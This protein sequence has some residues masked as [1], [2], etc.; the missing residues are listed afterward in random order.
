MVVEA[1]PRSAAEIFGE[2]LALA[3]KYA[4]LLA[5]NSDTLGLL[6]PRELEKLW[7]RHILNSAAV[8]ELISPGSSVADIGSGAGLPGIPLAIALPASEITLIEPMERRA[9]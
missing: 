7:T 8:A 4:Q 2:R 5:D 9:N 3:R 1:E 6:G